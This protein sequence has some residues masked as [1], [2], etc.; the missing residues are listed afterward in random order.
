MI[1][2]RKAHYYLC[3]LFA[4]MLPLAAQT[5]ATAD[6]DKPEKFVR[7]AWFACISAVP[8]GVENPVKVM[9]GKKLTELKLPRYMTSAPVKISADG[10]VRIVRE[11]PDPENP[12]EMKYLV[13]AEA[14]IPDNVR[15]ALIILA[16]LPEPK[17]DLIFVA[18][19][20]DL[21][22]FKGGDWLF[23]NL[24]TENIRVKL[25]DTVVDVP[26]KRV[27]V[28]DSPV[29]ATPV[30]VP[31]KFGYYYREQKKWRMFSAST[32]TQHATRREICIFNNGS[33]P[34]KIKKHG[35]L[36]PVQKK[37]P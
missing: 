24:S 16:P 1:I 32:I 12:E 21:A 37:K 30:R 9:S 10:I 7:T 18:K 22:D 33:R 34:G 20:Q 17:G 11:I 25:G 13:L 6:V 29:I 19:V 4:G 31:V 36:F 35:I 5:A 15:E 23:I 28:Y 3:F 27:E 26:P 8:D 2:M 14:K